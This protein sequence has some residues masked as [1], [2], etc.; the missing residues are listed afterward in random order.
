M[1]AQSTGSAD[2][3]GRF[4]ISMVNTLGFMLV[5]S[6]VLGFLA[7]IGV[8]GGSLLIIWL[9]L[10]LN[11]PHS[12]ARTMNL[13]FFI[14]SAIIASLFRWRQGS[15]D[16]C[17]LLP[18]IL[19]GCASAAIFSLISKVID[20]ELIKKLFGILLLFTGFRELCYRQRKPK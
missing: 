16:L 5:I 8:G 18:G 3:V 10:A 2:P 12:T 19:A 20:L 6:T 7:G 15:L 13:L 1:A 11:M 17:K 4:S 9:T 14:P